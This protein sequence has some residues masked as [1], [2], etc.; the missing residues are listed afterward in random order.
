MWPRL[1]RPPGRSRTLPTLPRKATWRNLVQRF[2]DA[3]YQ[4]QKWVAEHTAAEVAQAIAPSFPD[5]DEALLAQVVERYQEIGAWN[6]DP[7]MTEE[8]F[9]RLQMVMEQAGELAKRADYSAVVNNT[10]AEKAKKG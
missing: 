5:T 3:V 4:G 10:F 7:V 9:D 8:S 6:T 2:T 1:V